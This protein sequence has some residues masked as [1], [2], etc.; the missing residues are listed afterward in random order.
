MAQENIIIRGDI[1][2]EDADIVG[3]S[4][5]NTT[6]KKVTITDAQGSFLI[7]ASLGDTL[8]IQGIPF[9]SQDIEVT[10]TI[11]DQTKLKI[12]LVRQINDLDT[13]Q[14]S[15]SIL[16]G[17]IIKDGSD[18]DIDPVKINYNPD[19]VNPI[20]SEERRLHSA[21]TRP[22][23]QVGQDFL[24]FDVSLDNILNTLSGRKKRLK[25]NIKTAASSRELQK[26][27]DYYPDSLY[28][29]H[30]RI[31]VERIDDFL[32][33][34]LDPKEK[35]KDIQSLNKLE[36]LDYFLSR[37]AAYLSIIHKQSE[38]FKEKKQ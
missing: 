2:N 18:T 38:L 28:A 24:R 35:Q 9:E 31:P 30:L 15:N 26:I 37:R 29:K 5:I 16:S 23:D 4:V 14:L 32:L 17:N 21:T 20:S 13:I 7:M 34:I 10:Q 8:R 12:T 25:K 6:L 36:V 1:L 19:A 3:L 11:L 22:T 27:R 33:W